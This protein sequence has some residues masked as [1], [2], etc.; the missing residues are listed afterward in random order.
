MV[1]GEGCGVALGTSDVNGV[2]E[3]MHMAVHE[4]ILGKG[5]YKIMNLPVA[6]MHQ[7]VVGHDI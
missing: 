1:G 4:L 7:K 6:S 2:G 3:R 5:M